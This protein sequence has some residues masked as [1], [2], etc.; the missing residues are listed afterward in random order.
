[1]DPKGDVPGGQRYPLLEALLSELGMKPK[2]KYTKSDI[3]RMFDVTT[4]TVEKYFANG[5]LRKRPMPGRGKCLSCD[6]E[7]MLRGEADLDGGENA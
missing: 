3:A 7:E 6:L 2:G 5:R 4:R 1:M